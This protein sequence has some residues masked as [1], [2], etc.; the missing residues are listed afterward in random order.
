MVAGAVLARRDVDVGG[1]CSEGV[2]GALGA[3]AVLERVEL[4]P[5]CGV[6][7]SHL[8]DLLIG[9]F[10]GLEGLPQHLG[11]GRPGRVGVGKVALEGD[12]VNADGVAVAQA[13]SVVDEAALD[14]LTKD[15]TGQ[16]VAEVGPGPGAVVLVDEVGLLEEVG[17]PS[18]PRLRPEQ[19]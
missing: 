17:D 16:L 5:A 19:A 9:E 18:D 13:G 6:L 3:V 10:S 4:V 2:D 14:M 11:S 7:P 8:V 1:L 12:H 15:L